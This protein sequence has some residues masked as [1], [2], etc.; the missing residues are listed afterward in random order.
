M[1]DMSID[2]E[3]AL[4]ESRNFL[5][6]TGSGALTAAMVFGAAGVLSSGAAVAQTAKEEKS[7]E[8]EADHTMI[9]ATAY[10]LGASRSYPTM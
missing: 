6:L 1:T 9:I 7:R 2:A 8:V 4:S 10:I 5:K 3:C